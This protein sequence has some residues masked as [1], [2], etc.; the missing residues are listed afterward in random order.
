[1][2]AAAVLAG[3]SEP[4]GELEQVL[5]LLRASSGCEP[6]ALSVGEG[7]RRLL[8]L[9]REL[10][11]RDVEL[12]A[13]CGACGTANELSLADVPEE[14]PRVAV[15]GVGGGVRAP[16]YGDL[17]GL[18]ADGDA[19]V[20]ELLRRCTVGSPSR[21]PSVEDLE[22]VDDSL[23]GP[24][25]AACVDCGAPLELAL[26]VE[27]LVLA[28]LQ[29]QL[30]RIDHEIHLLARAYHWELDTIERLPDDRRARLAGLVAEER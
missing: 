9:H 24:L 7:D 12:I 13:V 2:R 1:M 21:A 11:G 19:A 5:A 16:A 17:V 20:A 6:E 22:E 8:A 14:Q 18:P 28:G 23:V 10:T 30:A 4:G 26:D 29:E 15:C 27:P 3:L 25:V